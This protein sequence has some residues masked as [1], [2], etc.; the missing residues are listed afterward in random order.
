MKR[1]RHCELVSA[2]LY[3]GKHATG[4]VVLVNGQPEFH[5]KT[6]DARAFYLR[7]TVK[8]LTKKEKA[9]IDNVE[10]ALIDNVWKFNGGKK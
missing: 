8:S 5:G 6:K 9:L 4:S 1:K 10:K 2:R 3:Y 7:L